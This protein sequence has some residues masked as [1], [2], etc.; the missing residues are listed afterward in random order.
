M[1]IENLRTFAQR[2]KRLA[3]VVAVLPLALAVYVATARHAPP[4]APP[5]P[6][7]YYID[8]ETG[9]VSTRPASDVPP[10]PGKSG[11]PTIVRAIYLTA[12]TVDQKFL[13][14]YEKYT[15]AAK[16]RQSQAGTTDGKISVVPFDRNVFLIRR[17]EAGSP[18]VNAGSPEG[19]KLVD[20]IYNP[21]PGAPALRP[22]VPQ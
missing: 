12:S 4:E 22:C 17:P 13:A 8:E 7:A 21:R 16:A 3:V 5:W 18:W 14:Y 6:M 15:D 11:R 2:H 19:M 9:E 20:A 10:L 1:L